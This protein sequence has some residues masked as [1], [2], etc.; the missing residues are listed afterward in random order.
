M[1]KNCLWQ[2]KLIL[3]LIL[4]TKKIEC[5]KEKDSE[6]KEMNLVKSVKQSFRETNK[7][8]ATM[9]KCINAEED[10]NKKMKRE[11]KHLIK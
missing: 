9:H 8:N 6:K 3:N 2:Q 4:K 10:N 1:M 11:K 5:E 7:I